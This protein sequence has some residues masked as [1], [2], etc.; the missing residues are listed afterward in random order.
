MRT[1]LMIAFL[2]LSV[3]GQEKYEYGTNEEMKGL[4]SV[5]ISTQG[6]IKE[7]QTITEEL[8][9]IGLVVADEAESADMI[10]DFTSST[11]TSAVSKTIVNTSDPAYSTQVT[12]R[13]KTKTG[14][15]IVTIKGKKLPRVVFNF[16]GGRRNPAE[17][18][19]KEFVKIY[20]KANG[21]SKK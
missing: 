11:N 2:S 18:F 21:I 15:A 4:K 12:E 13:V 17:K 9:K 20:M 10:I 16:E 8:T 3:L 7:R 14:T 5:Y 19:A 1:L 6:N